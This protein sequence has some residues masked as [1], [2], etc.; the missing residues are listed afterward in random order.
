MKD[1]IS[2]NSKNVDNNDIICKPDGQMT[3]PVYELLKNSQDGDFNKLKQLIDEKEMDFQGSTL[4]LALRNLIFGFKPNKPNYLKCFKFLLTK[5]ID[6]NYKYSKDNNST[7]L[8]RLIRL[9]EIILLKELLENEYIHTNTENIIF[10]SK[11]EEIEY[12][13]TQKEI[14][15]TQK[16][17]NNNNF[18]HYLLHTNINFNKIE[19]INLFEYIYNE[20][21]FNNINNEKTS[22]KI[23]NIFNKLLLE[24]NND[25]DN[26]MN[27]CL[28]YG[29]PKLVLKLI[30]IFG[31]KQNVNKKK[32]NYIHSAVIGNNITCLK[33]IMHYSSINDLSEKNI[34]NLTPAQLANK[35]GYTTM[36]SIINEYQNNFNEDGYKESIYKN[37]DLNDITYSHNKSIDLLRHFKDYKY[38]QLLYELNELKIINNLCTEG[39]VNNNEDEVNYKV[40]NLKIEWNIILIKI[41]E[42]NY[43]NKELDNNFSNNFN[44]NKLGKYN[45]KRSKKLEE[46]NKYT[47][48]PYFKVIQDL[49]ENIFSDKFILSFV[50]ISNNMPNNYINNN[51]NLDLLIYNKIIFYFK[52]GNFN[53]LINTAE[54]YLTKIYLKNFDTNSNI[55]NRYLI[56][57]LNLTCILIE[58]FIYQEYYSISEVLIK[59]L[60]KYLYT[61]SLNFSDTIYTLNDMIIFEYLNKNEILNPF[62]SNWNCL[63]NY[64]DL[65]KLLTSKEKS[66]EIIDDLRKKI[67][68]VKYKQ[69]IP[70]LNRIQL[71][72][73]CIEIKK[74]YEREDDAI[75]RKVTE[76]KEMGENSEMYYFN[77]VGI[78]YLKRKKY[79]LSIMLFKKG[80]NRYIEILKNKNI[81][82]KNYTEKFINFRIDYIT[83]FL[84]NISLCHFYL[85]EYNKSIIILELLLSFKNNQNNYFFYYRLG[86]C[87]LQIYIIS[88]K[89]NYDCY[90]SNI[91]KLFGYEKNK[92]NGKKNK[93][94]K[95]LSVDLDNDS[96]E[97]LS[98]QLDLDFRDT[99]LN[100][101]FEDNKNLLAND[102]KYNN[103][104]DSNYY[105]NYKEKNIKK[106]ILKNSTQ[107]L[108]V[109]KINNKNIIKNNIYNNDNISMS[110]NAKNKNDLM[111][112]DFLD[113][114]IKYLKKVLIISKTNFHTES[115]KSLYNFYLSCVKED[116]DEKDSINNQKRKKISNELMVDTYLNLLLCLS[117]KNNWLE[118]IFIIKDYNN[119]R[120]SSN[121]IINLKIL[122]FKFEAYINLNNTSKVREIINKLKTYKKAEFSVFNQVNNDIIKN[123]NIKLY[124]YY[125]L[126][127]IFIKEK[128][129]KEMDIYA[130][131]MV[132]LMKNEKN[133]PYYII[134]L[135]INVFLIKLNNEP[136]LNEKNKFKYNNIILN[137]IKNKKTNKED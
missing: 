15:F 63:F 6:L 121:K 59:A 65:L 74:L 53:S 77:I 45:K 44:N 117:L 13:I 72:F 8:M 55:N 25:G 66:K 134:D 110:I 85:Q 51:Q 107:N 108:N 28:F 22:K 84:Y 129:Y 48:C 112:K 91:L 128:K 83:A 14:L 124:L 81:K 47:I 10:H 101:L 7:I 30:K 21:P 100:K 9:G 96:T 97:N 32:N 105:N 49:N 133:I 58:I 29:F 78:L 130:E 11:E 116:K 43:D 2:N 40:M 94:E 1:N 33:I 87:Y 131:K 52:L 20:Y 75:Y 37:F 38:K 62:F 114:S 80:L 102:K 50:D 89:N 67:D 99:I 24:V 118:M 12:E 137:L 4:N 27:M 26:F 56:L 5:N 123:I 70:F 16:D 104:S 127:L 113:K 82:N 46:K 86:I 19:S 68:I 57:Y 122:L 95:P 61:K 3:L 36:N 103:Y 93:N 76:L 23:Q 132:S 17:A 69:E 111:K 31:F 90:N 92:N 54:I 125:N 79:H 115:M 60:Y 34:D 41:C 109:N 106:I 73:C 71:L 136:N 88:N 126:T 98:F 64:S 120:I 35:L 119:R 42:F 18:F 39:L 135:L